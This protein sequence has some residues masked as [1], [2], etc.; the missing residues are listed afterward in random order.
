MVI[1]NFNLIR[2]T[3]FPI[4]AEAIPVINAN[5]VSTFPIAPEALKAVAGWNSEIAQ[6]PCSIQDLQLLES[7]SS[8][9]CGNTPAA[10]LAPQPP[11]FAV[12]KTLDHTTLILS[13]RVTS[14]KR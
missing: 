11:G 4:K 13:C 8:Q 3:I 1:H 7:R 2:I 14:V 10:L 5:A 12:P 6:G 9:I